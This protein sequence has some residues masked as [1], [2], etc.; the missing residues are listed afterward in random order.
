MIDLHIHCLPGVDDGARDMDEAIAM[1]RMAADSGCRAL[2]ATPHQR[3]E[4]WWNSDSNRLRALLDE[5]SEAVGELPRLYLGGEIRIDSAMLDEL[6]RH[7]DSGLLPLAGSSYLLIEFNRF[8]VGPNPKEL[9]H[10][11]RLAGWRPIIAHPEFIP[12]LADDPALLG[13]LVALGALLQVTA[14]SV[15][16]D[17]G[18]QPRRRVA[19]ML[20]D[21]VVH[22][23]ASDAHSVDWRPPGLS[24]AHQEIA[25]LWGEDTAD[26]LAVEN[27]LAVLED[28]PI[29]RG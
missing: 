9:V 28:R 12:E 23:V 27:P 2:I 18:R 29:A 15:T 13:E 25:R 10:E 22:F 24:R 17:F 1:C 19:R 26:R 7:P 21:G 5:L 4:Q 11:L 14:M 20:S 8:G 16:G 3:N 6:L